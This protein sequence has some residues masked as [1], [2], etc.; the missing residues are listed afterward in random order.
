MSSP[1]EYRPI[2]P[3]RYAHRAALVSLELMD[4]WE[5]RAEDGR[6]LLVDWGE[7]DKDGLFTPTFTAI[8]DG[9]VLIDRVVLAELERRAS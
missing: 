6:R 3:L 1:L 2:T 8:D 4:S 5:L 7:P 9:K